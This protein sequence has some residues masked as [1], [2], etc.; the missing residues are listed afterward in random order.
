MRTY[1]LWVEI[2]DNY[3]SGCFDILRAWVQRFLYKL[4]RYIPGLA[5]SVRAE[6][7]LK[8]LLAKIDKE[9]KIFRAEHQSALRDR[10]RKL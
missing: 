10:R 5:E 1:K 4:F 9:V 3:L 7:E 6:E 8:Q 2:A